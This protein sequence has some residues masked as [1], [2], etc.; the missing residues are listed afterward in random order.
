M[1][2]I[3]AGTLEFVNNL[4]KLGSGKYQT[5]EVWQDFVIMT[6]CAIS[7]VTD[8]ADNHHPHREEMYLE[9]VK[10]Y[11]KEE[12]LI[13]RSLYFETVGAYEKNP[14]QDF[15]GE[16][17]MQLE[18]GNH[19]KGQFFTPYNLCEA[20][21]ELSAPEACQRIKEQG[22]ITVL[23]P[24]CGAGATLLGFANTLMKRQYSGELKV[25]WQNHVLFIGQDIDTVVGLM[26]YIQMSL[27]GCAGFV[28]IGNSLTK[29]LTVGEDDTDYWYTTMYF[30]EVWHT[31]RLA[32]AM[33]RFLWDKP[34]EVSKEEQQEEKQQEAVYVVNEV[35][36]LTFF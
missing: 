24:T 32:N 34:K 1:A 9:R 10:K 31:R 11:T 21:A 23:D 12:L 26:C 33:D 6:A 7:N 5:W 2:R 27:L 18:L 35:G 29:P 15:L 13:M 20:M 30:H 3:K 4:K 16:M 19:W 25:N 14:E 8:R 36:Q 17:Y 28:K 22:Y